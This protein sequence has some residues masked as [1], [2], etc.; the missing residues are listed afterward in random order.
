[1]CLLGH[2]QLYPKY[3]KKVLLFVKKEEEIYCGIGIKMKMLDEKRRHLKFEH[4]T[5]K[6]TYFYFDKDVMF[7]KNN[8]QIC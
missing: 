1:M 4:F 5:L 3:K 8:D 7:Y 2:R 6:I